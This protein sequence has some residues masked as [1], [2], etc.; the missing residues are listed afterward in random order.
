MFP[1]EL[2]MQNERD[3]AG[4]IGNFEGGA[5]NKLTQIYEVNYLFENAYLFL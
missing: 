5:C 3:I 1:V 4:A 2:T